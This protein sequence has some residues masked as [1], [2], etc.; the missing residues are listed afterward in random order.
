M[1]FQKPNPFPAMSIYENV[2]RRPQADRPARSAGREDGLVEEC[3]T[4]GRAVG[5]GRDR[6]GRPAARCRAA[7]SS[8]CASPGRWRCSPRAADGRALLRARPDL[9]PG[10]E[11][12]IGSSSS[13]VTIVIVTHNMQQAARVSEQCA[14]FLAGAD[15]PGRI[16]EYGTPRRCSAPARPADRR[17]RPRPVRLNPRRLA[18]VLFVGLSLLL[19]SAGGAPGLP[20]RPSRAPARPGLPSR[21]TSGAWTPRARA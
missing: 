15:S 20:A 8:G 19:V 17:L 11:E 9:D 13:E 10:I 5:R 3:L 12:T 6:L 7:S 2:A 1:V 21:S 18:A 4:Q 14:F 16:V